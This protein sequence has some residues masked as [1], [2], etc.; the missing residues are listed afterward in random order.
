MSIFLAFVCRT[1]EQSKWK[2]SH[3]L[4]DKIIIHIMKLNILFPFWMMISLEPQSILSC[5]CCMSSFIGYA[6]SFSLLEI[7]CRLCCWDNKSV[8]SLKNSITSAV[9]CSINMTRVLEFQSIIIFA[10]LPCAVICH[11]QKIHCIFY[12]PHERKKK[13][14]RKMCFFFLLKWM[15]EKM[16]FLG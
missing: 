16:K 3:K 4:I 6:F 8:F 10:F 1:A 11:C 5:C 2:R 14:H 13:K 7:L 15:N 12:Y 9:G